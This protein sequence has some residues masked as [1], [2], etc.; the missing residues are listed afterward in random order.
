M[1]HLLIYLELFFQAVVEGLVEDLLTKVTIRVII[2]DAK[3]GRYGRY[4]CAILSKAVLIFIPCTPHIG[5]ITVNTMLS[6]VRSV[7][8]RLA[9]AQIE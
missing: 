2:G 6:I 8:L 5:R 1:P 7:L 4:I 3:S 9:I